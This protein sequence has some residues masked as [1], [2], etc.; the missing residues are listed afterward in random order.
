VK[1]GR[2]LLDA[3]RSQYGACVASWF[4]SEATLLDIDAR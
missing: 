1:S 3:A 4:F 2:E